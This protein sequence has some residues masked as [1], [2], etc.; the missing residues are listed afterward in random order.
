MWGQDRFVRLAPIDFEVIAQGF[1]LGARTVS[2]ASDM[3]GALDWAFTQDGPTLLSVTI[4]PEEVFRPLRSKIEQRK[5]DL[6]AT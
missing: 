1:G 4:D 2:Q 6:L 3:D 5:R